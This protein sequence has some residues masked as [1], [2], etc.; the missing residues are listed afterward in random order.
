[1]SKAEKLRSRIAQN[2]RNV[3]YEDLHRLCVEVFGPPRHDG[4]SHAVFRTPWPGDP[5]VNIQ[6]GKNGEAKPY[7]VK[8]V[9]AAIEK[10]EEES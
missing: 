1:M 5:R 6:R 8:Q 9:L 7:Q 3:R 2:P 10:M 4:G